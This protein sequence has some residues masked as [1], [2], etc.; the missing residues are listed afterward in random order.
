MGLDAKNPEYTVHASDWMTMRDF[1][2]GETQVKSKH[3]R[4]LPATSGMIAD[5]Y[6]SSTA[7]SNI[8]YQAYE[9]YKTR[10][11]FPDYV[12]EAVE[13]YVGLLH[14]KE[15]TIELPP[16]LEFIRL[17]A[18]LHGESLSMLLRRINE[19]QLV[20]GRVGLLLDL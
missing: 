13:A 1:Y 3:T 6:G 19:E 12:K 5:G 7:A 14:L 17:N 18:T 9:A 10:A 11:V 4:Y 20:T 2:R 15:P 8:G 16:E